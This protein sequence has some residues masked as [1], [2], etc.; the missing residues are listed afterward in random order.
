MS[1]VGRSKHLVVILTKEVLFRPW[2]VVEITEAHRK[3]VKLVPL[4]VKDGAFEQG[5]LQDAQK[6]R[7]AISEQLKGSAWE[8]VTNAYSGKIG[9]DD[10]LAAYA[11]LAR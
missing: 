7:S 5:L 10:V 11:A 8:V 2:C 6:L 3:G 4:V 9:M 1:A